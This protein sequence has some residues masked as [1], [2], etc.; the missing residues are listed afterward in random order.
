MKFKASLITKSQKSSSTQTELL[1]RYRNEKNLIHGR[2]TATISIFSALI[3]ETYPSLPPQIINYSF[4][5]HKISF[6]CRSKRLV[7]ADKKHSTTS[8][9]MYGPSKI[10]TYLKTSSLVLE[11][12]ALACRW[13]QDRIFFVGRRIPEDFFWH[14]RNGDPFLGIFGFSSTKDH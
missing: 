4:A 9:F 1:K 10:H 6:N 13:Q 2:V 11:D 7:S 8:T 14:Q 5:E 12:T 3:F